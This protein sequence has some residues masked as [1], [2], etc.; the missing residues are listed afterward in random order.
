MKQGL[1]ASINQ[2]IAGA[3]RDIVRAYLAITSANTV[4]HVRCRT[5]DR[6]ILFLVLPYSNT[7]CMNVFLQ[8]LSTT[9]PGDRIILVCDGASWHRS[10]DIILP[11]NIQM[12][13]LPPATPEMN[14]SSR[15]GKK[16]VKEDFA[17]RFFILL[18]WL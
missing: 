11:E 17:T 9:Y 4:M 5:L 15:F 6:R 16:S 13:F 7:V 8:E 2:S 14:L 1:D 10:K 3:S 12:I 18:I